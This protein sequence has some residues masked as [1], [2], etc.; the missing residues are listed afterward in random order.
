MNLF[1]FPVSATENK[2]VHLFDYVWMYN[3]LSTPH[4]TLWGSLIFFLQPLRIQVTSSKNTPYRL[5]QFTYILWFYKNRLVLAHVLVLF[6]VSSKKHLHWLINCSTGFWAV[7]GHLEPWE[8]DLCSHQSTLVLWDFHPLA[9]AP[10]LT[11]MGAQISPR[12]VAL[13]LRYSW[14]LWMAKISWIHLCL[15]LV[16]GGRY[17]S[18]P[19]S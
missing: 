18:S 11:R 3:W 12:C 10:S 14:R 8:P 5:L 4:R 1:C 13:G 17:C 15:P 7:L 6:T 9:V 2:E 19:P 16:S